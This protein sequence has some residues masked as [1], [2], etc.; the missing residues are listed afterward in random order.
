[1]IVI[2]RPFRLFTNTFDSEY[3]FRCYCRCWVGGQYFFFLILSNYFRWVPVA[4][5]FKCFNT[6]NLAHL[7]SFRHR[8]CTRLYKTTIFLL[9][10]LNFTV[11]IICFLLSFH[12]TGFTRLHTYTCVR[13]LGTLVYKLLS[14]LRR[15][16]H[17]HAVFKHW[18]TVD[19]FTDHTRSLV[20]EIYSSLPWDTESMNV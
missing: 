3:S 17:L 8:L 19:T 4:R 13:C 11:S 16:T 14:F 7:M 10:S 20:C 1:M 12:F 15:E 6:G 9:V 5:V 18:V 2:L